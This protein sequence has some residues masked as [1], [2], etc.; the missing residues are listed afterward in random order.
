MSDDANRWRLNV[1]AVIMDSAGNLLLARKSIESRH[2]HFPQGGVHE[3]ETYEHAVVR[4]VEEEVGLPRS[5]YHIVARWGGLRYFYREKNR[6]SDDWDGQ[7]QTWFLMLCHGEKPE[8]D[9]T[10]STE[11]EHTTW[12]PCKQVK[13]EMFVSFKREVVMRVLGHFLPPG[14]TSI[15]QHLAKLDMTVAY[16]YRP[17]RPHPPSEDRSFFA[18]GK[19]EMVATMDELNMRMMHAQRRLDYLYRK[20]KTP[21]LRMLVL[22]CGSPGSNRKSCLRRIASCCDP[23]LTR[24]FRPE[25]QPEEYDMVALQQYPAESEIR[26]MCRRMQDRNFDPQL[27]DKHEMELAGSGVRLLHFHLHPPG[28]T[29]QEPDT[30]L[31]CYYVP[32]EK[33]WY[34]DF[35]ITNILVETLE[36]LLAESEKILAMRG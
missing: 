27:I 1:A 25:W 9:C 15:H 4:E 32:C 34:R 7:Q 29:F 12:V 26:L 8:T 28:G 13:P 36:K 31:P 24:A 19:E 35:V 20:E 22:I 14:N 5:A 3:G 16:R 21:P 18:G 23:L 17:D 33:K 11:F 2:L 10:Y 6:K 30:M